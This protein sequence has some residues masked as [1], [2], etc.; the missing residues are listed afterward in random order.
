MAQLTAADQLILT[1]TCWDGLTADEIAEILRITPSAVR[2]RLHRARERLRQALAIHRQA[3][4]QTAS[5]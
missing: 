1:L 5:R 2:Q 4:D 3:T